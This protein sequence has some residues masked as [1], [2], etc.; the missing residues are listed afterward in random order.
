[1]TWGSDWPVALLAGTY[2]GWLDAARRLAERLTPDERAAIL[3]GTAARI[4]GLA[5]EG[6]AP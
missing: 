6:E 2:A 1:M 3:G 4:H 5:R